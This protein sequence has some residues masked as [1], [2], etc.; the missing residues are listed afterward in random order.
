M[1]PKVAC[2]FHTGEHITNFC[3]DKQ[4]LLPLCPTCVKIHS[5]EHQMM[6]TIPR[7]EE[8]NQLTVGVAEHLQR[9]A[10]TIEA[11]VGSVLNAQNALSCSKMRAIQSVD[12]FRREMQAEIEMFCEGV[13]QSITEVFR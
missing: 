5:L 8:I 7:Y 12:I 1:P 2:A 9:D 6:Q 3:M 13:Q 11:D 4:C 10:A